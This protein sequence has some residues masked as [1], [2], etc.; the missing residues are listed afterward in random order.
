MQ[1]LKDNDVRLRKRSNILV[2]N[3][4]NVFLL[5]NDNET[6]L[7]TFVKTIV[8]NVENYKPNC[9]FEIRSSLIT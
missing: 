7:Y 4:A 3:L 1:S 9:F 8:L 5:N 2:F 6:F